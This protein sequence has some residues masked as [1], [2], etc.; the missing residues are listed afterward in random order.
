ML[1]AHAFY[2]M[3]EIGKPGRASDRA[4]AG[5][6]RPRDGAPVI[7]NGAYAEMRF[8]G[9]RPTHAARSNMCGVS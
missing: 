9:A 2:L 8:D 1:D 4:S 5:S 7:A 6:A 3:P